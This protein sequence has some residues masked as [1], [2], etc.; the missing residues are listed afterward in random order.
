M[1]SAKTSPEASKELESEALV[2]AQ[3]DHH[4]NLVSLVGVVT[5]GDPL[6]LI[7]G[8]CEHGSLLEMLRT[9]AKQSDPLAVPLKLR[10]C[11]DAA[12]GMQHLV[13]QRFI[14]RDLAA[15]NVLVATGMVGKVADFGR[16]IIGPLKESTSSTVKSNSFTK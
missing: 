6:V 12:K 14:H 11:L 15:R 13:K 10:L 4:P 2:M 8:F 7:V 5:R 3:V 9:R 1:L 16:P